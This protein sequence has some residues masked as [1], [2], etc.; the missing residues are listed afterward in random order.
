M[1]YVASIRP[2]V[3][4]ENPEKKVTELAAIFGQK[5]RALSEKEKQVWKD[6]AAALK[7]KAEG[8]IG[9]PKKK[10]KTAPDEEETDSDDEDEPL[11]KDPTISK[12]ES[13]IDEIMA[14]IDLSTLTVR[15]IKEMLVE[16]HNFSDEVVTTHKKHIKTYVKSKVN[17]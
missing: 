14:N 8:G 3:T 15:K 16:S 13:A 10:K 2:K 6:K 7:A 9:P 4:A 5:W 11:G 17:N 12:L 1:L